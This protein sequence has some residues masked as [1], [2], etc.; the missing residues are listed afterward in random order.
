[1]TVENIY[2][3][4]A[5]YRHT[6]INAKPKD[7]QPVICLHREDVEKI[8][9]STWKHENKDDIMIDVYGAKGNGFYLRERLTY[10]TFK[11]AE[12]K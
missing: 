1:M 4:T 10:Q 11:K 7:K 2:S 5:V 3:V 8:V 9:A 12:F 6:K